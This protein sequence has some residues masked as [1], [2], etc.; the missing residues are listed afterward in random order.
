M[1]HLPHSRDRVACVPARVSL[2]RTLNQVAGHGLFMSYCSH[3]AGSALMRHEHEEAYIGVVLRGS[4]QETAARDI[5]CGPGALV[6]HPAGHVH[7]NRFADKETRC[8]NLYF[9]AHWLE[10]PELGGLFTD[11]RD[12]QTDPHSDALARL[13]RELNVPDAISRIAIS[14]AALD[15]VSEALRRDVRP[16]APPWLSAVREAIAN[17]PADPPS[18][19][20]L[21]QIARVHPAHLSRA[22]RKATGETLGAFARRLR[23]EAAERWLVGGEMSLAQVA[24]AAGFY[25]QAHFARSYRRRFGCS[26]SARRR[27][28]S[29]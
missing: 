9:D 23:L 16:L 3:A 28:I 4:H 21:A 8:I 22:Y 14:A 1:A 24:A 15:L 19:A 11:Y 26:P 13:E 12:L 5:A 18:L 25:D 7:A 10:D 2:G 17:G 29:S 20:Q 27:Q 6:A